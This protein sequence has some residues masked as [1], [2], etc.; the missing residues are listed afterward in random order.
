MADSLLDIIVVGGGIGGLFA[1]KA[2]T[3]RGLR[4]SVYEQ[5]P[6]LGEVGA[7]VFVTPNS[8]RHLQR[9]GLGPE[10]ERRGARVGFKSEYF[11][12]IT[13]PRSLLC[14]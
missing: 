3:A 13:E 4:V 9:V 11:R 5:A 12:A 6:A 2:M 10:V 1:A 7:G 8:M 14:R